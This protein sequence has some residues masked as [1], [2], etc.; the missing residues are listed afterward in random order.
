MRVI[1]VNRGVW[2]KC[3]ECGKLFFIGSPADWIYK[4]G[5]TFFHTWSCMRKYDERH[6]NDEHERRSAAAYKVAEM[7]KKKQEIN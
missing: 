3:H 7:R 2:N 6:K 5:S 4:R 1:G